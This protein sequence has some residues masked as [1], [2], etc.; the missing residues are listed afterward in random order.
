MSA[1]SLLYFDSAVVMAYIVIHLGAGERGHL[2]AFPSVGEHIGDS[3]PSGNFAR[4]LESL[5]PAVMSHA[6]V[7]GG[8]MLLFLESK[9]SNQNLLTVII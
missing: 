4:A 9:F 6:Y 1:A 2:V 8:L 7:V 3:V 5:E